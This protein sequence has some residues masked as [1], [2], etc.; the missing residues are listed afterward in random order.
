MACHPRLQVTITFQ[1]SL[2]S[3]QLAINTQDW[4]G[5]ARHCA[6][7][8]SLPLEVISGPFAQAAVVSQIDT[9]RLM[10]IT[11]SLLQKAIFPQRRRYSLQENIFSTSSVEILIKRRSPAMPLLSLA[12]SNFFLP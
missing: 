11:C 2:S 12:F 3:L 9:M 8:M 10:L 1:S 7:A 6:R 5:A 4:E